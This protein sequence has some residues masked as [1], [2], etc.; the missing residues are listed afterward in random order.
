MANDIAGRDAV[1]VKDRPFPSAK[2]HH[3]PKQFPV[4]PVARQAPAKIN[5]AL[6]VMGRRADGYHRL[7]S[8]VTFTRLGD[9]ITISPSDE[10][11]FSVRGPFETRVPRDRSNLVLRARDGLRVAFPALTEQPV[12]ID[13]EKNLPVASG[14]GGGSSDAAQA[15]RGLA[16]L[17]HIRDHDALTAI[18]Q[19]LGAD[20]PMCL[21]AHPL[22]ARGIGEILE[23][24]NGFPSLPLVL[25][26]PGVELS[27]PAVFRT[28]V[29]RDNPPLPSLPSGL[30][31]AAICNWLAASRN[32][33]EPPAIALAPAVAE[34]LRALEAS[35]AAVARMSGSGATSF[36]LFET[37]EAAH[38]AAAAIAQAHPGWWVAATETIASEDESDGNL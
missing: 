21:A 8:L 3:A 11:R 25:V 9:R 19:G 38:E 27:T 35:G 37:K 10:D 15:L 2:H 36:G 30:D 12:A 14:I 16:E 24:L 29:S 6:H 22:T 26:N 32:D 4:K 23:P 1:S 20:V 31:V 17:W 34:T 33:L 7:E 18:G 13:L 28:L 5:L